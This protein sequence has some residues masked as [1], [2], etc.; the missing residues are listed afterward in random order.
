M[1]NRKIFSREEAH[2]IY[3]AMIFSVKSDRLRLIRSASSDIADKETEC[4]CAQSK[5]ES[6]RSRGTENETEKPRELFIEDFRNFKILLF[7]I[8]QDIVI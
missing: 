4:V 2:H 5:R 7:N 3:S 1:I 6:E 8:F